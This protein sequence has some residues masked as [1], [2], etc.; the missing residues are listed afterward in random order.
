M[1]L[2]I[3]IRKKIRKTVSLVAFMKV[4]GENSWIRIWI[5]LSEVWIGISTEMS[6]FCNT[7]KN[8]GDFRIFFRLC[9]VFNTVSSAAPQIPLCR[10]IL[11]SK[12]EPR[13]VATSASAVGRFDH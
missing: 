7:D 2:Q 3:V 9:I 13:T 4:T 6:R 1:L 11:G 10:R 5:R 12:F 8:N